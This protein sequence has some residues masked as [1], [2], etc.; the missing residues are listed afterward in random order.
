MEG[1]ASDEEE[2]SDS[3]TSEGESDTSKEARATKDETTEVARSLSNE[4]RERLCLKTEPTQ[5]DDITLHPVLVAEWMNW[6]RKGLYEG[7]EED[8]KKREEEESKMREEVMKKFHRKEILHVEAPKLNPEILAY[9]SGVAKNRDKHFVS[10]Q[11]ALG[12][13]MIAIAK[14]IS[15]ILDLEEGDIA[16]TKPYYK[17]WAMREN[18]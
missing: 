10:S 17:T 12:S 18:S 3:S 1:D 7:D 13:A 8:Y 15:L 16:S 2:R 9:I 14:G 6:M 5:S 4:T 11:N